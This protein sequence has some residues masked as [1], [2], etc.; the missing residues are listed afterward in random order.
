N[1]DPAPPA[2][3][4]GPY[5]DEDFAKPGK[6]KG[7][8][9]K[10]S[11]WIALALAV[12]GGGLYGGYRWTQTQYYVGANEDHVALFRGINQELAG[13]K[14]HKVDQDHPEIELKY[15]AGFQRKEL[16]E[17]I[18]MNSRD[19]A[20]AKLDEL[21]TQSE[22]CKIVAERKKNP[23][24][25]DKD[26]SDKG[27][28]DKDSGGADDSEKKR[29][30]EQNAPGD[31]TTGGTGTGTAGVGEAG[32]GVGTVAHTAFTSGSTNDTTDAA[33]STPS[34]SPELSEKQQ[35]LAKQCTGP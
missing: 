31:A 5:T 1:A 24:S 28:K 27:G 34:P 32:S 3:E 21:S 17:T 7:R 6:R 26:K 10:R 25:G 15:L 23:D 29:K 9:L 11:L 12:A 22:V 30:D 33:S 13:V 14:L 35:E 2:G 20:R 19:E 8:W 4:F 16:R 18:A